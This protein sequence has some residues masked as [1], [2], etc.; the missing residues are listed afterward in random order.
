MKFTRGED[1][2]SFIDTVALLC[3]SLREGETEQLHHR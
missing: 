2:P 1:A 3:G